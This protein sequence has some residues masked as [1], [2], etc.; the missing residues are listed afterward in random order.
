M[1]KENRLYTTLKDYFRVCHPSKARNPCSLLWWD[2]FSPTLQGYG[3]THH[4]LNKEL[5]GPFS[6]LRE[7][8]SILNAAQLLG[9]RPWIKPHRA[10]FWKYFSISYLFDKTA[11][12]NCAKLR[13]KGW[14]PILLKAHIKLFRRLSERL[15][16]QNLSYIF[17][18]HMINYNLL[19]L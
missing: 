18:C 8:T 13:S 10:I 6:L 16:E 4:S 11:I 19:N 2:W 17:K 5:P 15:M 7:R 14:L 1:P 9:S 3:L 12:I